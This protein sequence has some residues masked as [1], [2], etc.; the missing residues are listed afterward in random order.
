[1]LGPANEE[2]SL[3][4]FLDTY[5]KMSASYEEKGG[6]V[7][8]E[9]NLYPNEE[10]VQEVLLPTVHKFGLVHRYQNNLRK[11]VEAKRIENEDTFLD[12]LEDDKKYEQVENK[13]HR[14]SL[15]RFFRNAGTISVKQLGQS[16]G[17]KTIALIKEII[18]KEF[19]AG[20]EQIPLGED[21]VHFGKVVP[22]KGM[23]S[24]GDWV[25]K[26]RFLV[27]RT[28]YLHKNFFIM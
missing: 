5:H 10:I 24:P 25:G 6:I 11:K 12:H 26:I 21:L 15:M 17:K 1:M 8:D 20:I 2:E 19:P 28:L 27:F 18:D 23:Y 3:A 9:E 7:V 22:N 14:S 4:D 16:G 13:Q